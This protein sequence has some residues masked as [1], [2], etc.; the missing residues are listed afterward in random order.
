M[1]IRQKISLTILT[2]IILIFG[3]VYLVIIPTIS[4][5]KQISNSVFAERVDLEKKYLRGQLLKKTVADFEKI[6]P[7]QDRL[8]NVFIE[9]GNELN[10]VTAIETLAADNGIEQNIRLNASRQNESAFISSLPIEITAIGNFDNVLNFTSAIEK[11][12]FYF[13]SAAMTLEST[14][15]TANQDE[16]KLTMDGKIFFLNAEK[17]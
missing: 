1:K 14:N 2:V 9:A 17:K 10:F 12:P 7:Q 5:I 13:N 6:K 11:L 3:V 15:S 8:N 4:D 16:V